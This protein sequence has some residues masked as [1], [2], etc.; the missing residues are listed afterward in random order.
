MIYWDESL[1]PLFKEDSSNDQREWSLESLFE[2]LKSITL[3][4]VKQGE[5]EYQVIVTPT[6]KQRKLLDLPKI[7][8]IAT[9][10]K[11]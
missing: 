3:N 11:L 4:T 5:A 1:E 9:A 8:N 6:Q 10:L 7:S 2:T